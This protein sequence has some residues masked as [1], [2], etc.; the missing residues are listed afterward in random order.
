M[1][2]GAELVQQQQHEVKADSELLP[3]AS[4]TSPDG[5]QPE[6]EEMESAPTTD[7]LQE[8]EVAQAA[9][10]DDRRA[11]WAGLFNVTWLV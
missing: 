8:D 10:F 5:E 3:N 2:R 6:T 4:F 7:S 9:A 11:R 1:S